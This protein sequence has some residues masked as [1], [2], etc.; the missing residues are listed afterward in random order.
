MT[1]QKG[2]ATLISAMFYL[3]IS[4]A[5]LALVT[6]SAMDLLSRSKEQ[7]RYETMINSFEK[8][9]FAIKDAINNKQDVNIIIN[10]PEEIEIDCKNNMLLGKI[11]YKKE[12]KSEEVIINN[13]TI[14]KKGDS[15]YFEKE[16]V[17]TKRIKLSDDCENKYLAKGKR[18]IT[19]DYLGYDGNINIKIFENT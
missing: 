13:I 3:L 8:L 18:T 10:N 12:Y 15:L 14:S 17:S 6:T 1:N 4:F 11:T 9:D 7:A 5:I 19:V 16:L 2:A